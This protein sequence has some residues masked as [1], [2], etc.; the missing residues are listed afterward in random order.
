MGRARLSALVLLAATAACSP[1]YAARQTAGH[2]GLLA[3]SRS[4]DSSARDAR[5]PP[6]RR[7]AMK[8]ALAARRFGVE[9][10][11]L[12]RSRDYASWTPVADAVNWLVYACPKTSLMPVPFKVPLAGAFPYK[13]HFRRD[14]AEREAA[15]WR[16]K[17]YDAAVLPAAAYN[18]P[19]PF[20]DPLP[21]AALAWPPGELARL[22]FHEMV[23]GTVSLGDQSAE[24]ALASWAGAR[25]AEAFLA[26]RWGEGSPEL[27]GWREDEAERETREARWSALAERLRALYAE[28][29]PEA[30]K[31]ARRE[32][33]FAEFAVEPNNAVVA[34]R[35]VY[36]GDPAR[37]EALWA[38][39]GRDWRAFWEA[40]RAG[41]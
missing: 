11:G 16:A 6:G 38:S 17:G 20:A 21:S 12:R 5:V 37:W 4:L 28:P 7:E 3:R 36:R 26:A 35:A 25:G 8:T 39:S 10:L 13:G 14:L 31:L 18:T 9:V 22:I 34:A 41:R 29:V 19:L 27:A 33:V 32:A 1:L 40:V 2:L 23:H 15:R 24:E 30:E